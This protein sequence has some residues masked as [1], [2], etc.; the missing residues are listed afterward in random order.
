MNVNASPFFTSPFSRRRAGVVGG[1][2]H[3]LGPFFLATCSTH[4]TH[5]DTFTLL[6]PSLCLRVG[7]FGHQQLLRC[8]CVCVWYCV[9]CRVV[10]SLS[11]PSAIVGG[12]TKQ[13]KTREKKKEK[14][15][16]QSSEFVRAAHPQGLPSRGHTLAEFTQTGRTFAQVKFVCTSGVYYKKNSTNNDDMIRISSHC[17]KKHLL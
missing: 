4:T 9:S 3:H 15:N 1:G 7:T 8:V 12:K 16:G 17:F 13:K 10:I 14:K 6:V 5:R 11:L 2:Y